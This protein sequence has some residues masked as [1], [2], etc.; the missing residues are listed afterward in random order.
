VCWFDKKIQHDFCAISIVPLLLGPYKAGDVSG[1]QET[2]GKLSKQ[3]M[4]LRSSNQRE[5]NSHLNGLIDV[6]KSENEILKEAK[7]IFDSVEQ[8]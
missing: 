2:E 6:L 4:T 3:I 1:L 7:I 5:T 8:S